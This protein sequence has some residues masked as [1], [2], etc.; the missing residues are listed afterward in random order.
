MTLVRL[1]VRLILMTD[2]R[3]CP[4]LGQVLLFHQKNNDK[5][6]LLRHLRVTCIEAASMLLGGRQLQHRY[7]QGRL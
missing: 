3:F 4:M 6:P 1:A 5:N 2:F 7:P